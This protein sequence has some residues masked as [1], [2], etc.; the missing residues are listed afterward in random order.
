MIRFLPY[1]CVLVLLGSSLCLTATS[2]SAQS[3][4]NSASV[5][6]QVSAMVVNSMATTPLSHLTPG[7]VHP[8]QQVLRIDPVRDPRVAL[9]KFTGNPSVPV[10]ISSA[11]HDSL[12]SLQ[13]PSIPV[14]YR[15]NGNHPRDQSTS[16]PLQVA[17]A[18]IRFSDSGA[19]FLWVGYNLNTAGKTPGEYLGV[20][21][22]TVE[23]N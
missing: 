16:S 1:F 15:L 13:N 10:C 19:Y 8:E 6:M 12:S 7:S 9:Y 14:H 3:H 5:N 4:R 21:T 22:V 2:A 20:Y 11:L 23:Y 17:P 18:A